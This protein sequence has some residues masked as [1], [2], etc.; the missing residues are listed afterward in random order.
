MLIFSFHLILHKQTTLTESLNWIAVIIHS[1][2]ASGQSVV[3][4]DWLLPGSA[5]L[6]NK[7]RYWF[8][9]KPY[10]ILTFLWSSQHT[11]LAQLEGFCFQ[12]PSTAVY[13]EGGEGGIRHLCHP[14]IFFE[15]QNWKKELHILDINTRSCLWRRLYFIIVAHNS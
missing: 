6:K 8:G 11:G 7:Q 14:R 3:A 1:S 2:D 13:M 15:N 5:G 4:G 10:G 12:F 9:A